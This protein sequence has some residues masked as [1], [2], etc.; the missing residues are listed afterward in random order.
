MG[1]GVIV[2]PTAQKG[3]IILHRSGQ[4]L[5]NPRFGL[6][7]VC[8]SPGLFSPVWSSSLPHLLDQFYTRPW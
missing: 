3:T 4:V 5:M 8:A 6:L 2:P 7:L 1:S